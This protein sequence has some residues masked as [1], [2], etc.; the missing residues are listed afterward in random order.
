MKKVS[1]KPVE[2]GYSCSPTIIAGVIYLPVG[3]P[4]S[5][6][7]AIK[8]ADGSVLWQ[9]GTEPI[10][11]VG[12]YPISRNGRPM[13]VGYLKNTLELYDRRTGQLL[14]TFPLT[15]GYDEHSAWPIYREPI[16]WISAPFRAGSQW[17]E[18][19]DD[20]PPLIVSR[21]QTEL[22][23]NDVC[24]SVLVD[25]NLFGFDLRDAQTKMHRP[26]RGQFRCLDFVSGK[27]RW[28]NGPSSGI[29]RAE[30]NTENQSS[31]NVIGHASVL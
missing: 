6:M 24:S 18:I 12:A 16:L 3:A 23:S 29:R 10:S 17:F 5:T 13:I 14:A 30:T 31:S 27:E 25:N 28:S 26:S 21:S 7:V 20:D 2:F 1:A 8:A 9:S 22:M 19:T 11:H 4:N 15:A